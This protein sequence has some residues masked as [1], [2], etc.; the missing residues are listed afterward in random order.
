MR[1]FKLFLKDMIAALTS[2][3]NF[4]EGMTI[5]QVSHDDKTSSAVIRKFEVM[6][7]AA[8]NLPAWIK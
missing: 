2:I 5:D 1:D 6:G 3:E 8:R 7:E 4:M